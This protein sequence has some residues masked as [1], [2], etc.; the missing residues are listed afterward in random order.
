VVAE[1]LRCHQRGREHA[2]L[3]LC[4]RLLLATL[5][6]PT[7]CCAHL[8]VMQRMQTFAFGGTT[9]QGGSSSRASAYEAPLTFEAG[10]AS[11]PQQGGAAGSAGPMLPAQQGLRLAQSSGHLREPA[12]GGIGRLHS[13][14]LS[15]VGPLQLSFVSFV[16]SPAG[17]LEVAPQPAPTPSV[18]AGSSSGDGG[19]HVGKV[20]GNGGGSS[21]AA[22]TTALF[23]VA[24]LR[25]TPENS[26]GWCSVAGWPLR[27][28]NPAR[29]AAATLLRF[30]E[31]ARGQ[32]LVPQQSGQAAHLQVLSAEY[33]SRQ[34]QDW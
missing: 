13:P 17:G 15:T 29:H 14:D 3:A 31:T 23:E 18:Q 26:S 33:H 8:L 27:S 20:D 25:S 19:S 32:P 34:P 22:T 10:A 28:L 4:C 9:E 5:F 2:W 1:T 30:Q 6:V 7:S 24:A 11:G 21:S 16:A 12:G